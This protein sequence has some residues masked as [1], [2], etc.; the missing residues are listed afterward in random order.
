M[1]QIWSGRRQGALVGTRI[2]GKTQGRFARR[3]PAGNGGRWPLPRDVRRRVRLLFFLAF[4]AD[5]CAFA[6]IRQKA[7][8]SRTITEHYDT[9]ALAS[10][11]PVSGELRMSTK[12]ATSSEQK[13]EPAFELDRFGLRSTFEGYGSSGGNGSSS[14]W[15]FEDRLGGWSRT[16][17]TNDRY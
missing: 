16:A 5:C 9:R 6:T 13:R 15:R 3:E 11:S 4:S 10:W 14:P 1:S 17:P 2:H 7:S 8:A 12:N